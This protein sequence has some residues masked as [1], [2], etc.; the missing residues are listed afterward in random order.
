MNEKSGA[1]EKNDWSVYIVRCGDDTF[2]TG[3]AK[4]LEA[5]LHKHN[6]GQGA[7]Y[8]RARRPVS[9]VYREEKLTR[10]EALVR[11]ARIKALPRPDKERL[12]CIDPPR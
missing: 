6:S 10:S 11:E 1:R 2:Y 9:L 4:D 5:R 8:T 3:I 12:A 7:A